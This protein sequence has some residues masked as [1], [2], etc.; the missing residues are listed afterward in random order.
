MSWW[1]GA[2]DY[3]PYAQVFPDDQRAI[4]V[5]DTF[6]RLWLSWNDAG[7][8]CRA[9]AASQRSVAAGSA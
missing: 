1:A 3:A 6:D 7:R 2:Y 4:A 9:R 8:A 5:S